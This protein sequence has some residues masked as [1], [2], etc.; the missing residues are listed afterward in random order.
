MES[1]VSVLCLC[2]HKTILSS[3]SLDWPKKLFCGK[4]VKKEK[5]KTVPVTGHGGPWGYERSRLQHFLDSRLT[6]GSDVFS[7]ILRL[8]YTP[9]KVLVF[10][11]VGGW[12][13]PKAI[14]QLE[15]LSQL[16]NPVTSSGVKPVTFWLSV[17]TKYATVHPCDKHV[18]M[19]LFHLL[20]C[21]NF[22]VCIKRV[23]CVCIMALSRC[24]ATKWD[25]NMKKCHLRFLCRSSGFEH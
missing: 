22:V 11:S 18:L 25:C 3:C 23:G 1:T 7:L 21:V 5:C 13:E 17:P 8:P 4:H 10:I 15:G 9:R 2:A 20:N 16:E 19:L 24:G 14:V 12:V 6:D